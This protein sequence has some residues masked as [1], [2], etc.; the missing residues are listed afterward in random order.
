MECPPLALLL[1]QLTPYHPTVRVRVRVRLRV[2]LRL[3]VKVR[4]GVS[5]TIRVRG[6]GRVRFRVRVR[7][8]LSRRRVMI[9]VRGRVRLKEP[10]QHTLHP[11]RGRLR[12]GR[13]WD[14]THSDTS[15]YRYHLVY[16]FRPGL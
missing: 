12:R 11:G 16:R 5:V 3:R 13:A 6:R 14:T 9:S 10:L 4:I 2:R 8:R 1:A 15:K 7:V